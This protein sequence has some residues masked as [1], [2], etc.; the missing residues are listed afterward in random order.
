MDDVARADVVLL[1]GSNL[2]ENHPVMAAAVKRA[3]KTGTRLIVADP[4]RVDMARRAHVWLRP[5]PGTDTA[6]I[7]GMA[8]V[9]LAEGLHDAAYIAARTEGAEAFFASVAAYTPERVEAISGIPAQRLAKAARLYASG[10][11]AILYCMGITQHVGG[12]ETVKALANLAMLCGNVGREGGGV[13]PLRG[14]NNVQGACDMGG[15]PDR[16]PGYRSVSDA[17]AR[18]CLEEAWGTVLPDTPGM[19]SRDMFRAMEQGRLKGLYLVGENPMLSHANLNHAEACLDALDFLVVQDIFLTETAQRAHV[20]LPAACFAEKDGTFTNTERRVQRV[21]KAVRAPGDAWEDWRIVCALASRMG[22][23]MGYA[24]CAEIM[25]EIAAVVP[26]YAGIRHVRLEGGGIQWPCPDVRHPGT[27][28]LHTREFTRG[29]GL[30][31][32]VAWVPPAEVPDAE[33]PFILTTGRVLFQ[34]HTGTMTRRARGLSRQE[35]APFVEIAPQDAQRVGVVQG[36]MVRVVSRRGEI[37]VAARISSKAVEGT[38]FVPFHFAEAAANRL[39]SDAADPV[40]GISEFKV[41]AVR[42]TA[43]Q[44]L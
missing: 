42:L 39:T 10:R 21:R 33:Y 11:A 13:N 44:A 5:A 14:Q 20:V 15:L 2:S 32:A 34:Y 17:G 19:T 3:M 29:K 6:W 27:P 36:G 37:E 35:P 25:R 43:I 4:R 16:L 24:S 31:H 23:P 38:V 26:L 41:C 9:I 1:A 7:L 18:R 8:H 40:A 12:T 22:Y 30:F 28:I